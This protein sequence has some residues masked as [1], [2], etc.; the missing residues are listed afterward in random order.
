MDPALHCRDVLLLAMPTDR[1]FA[2]GN[3]TVYQISAWPTPIV[4]HIIEVHNVVSVNCTFMYCQ[5]A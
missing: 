1:W 5:F 4:H 3:I 2:T